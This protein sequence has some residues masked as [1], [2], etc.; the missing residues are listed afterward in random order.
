M[1]DKQ[2]FILPVD[3]HDEV[4]DSIRITD[5]RTTFMHGGILSGVTAEIIPEPATLLLGALAAVGMLVRRRKF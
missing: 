3:F 4:L 2:V 1:L 5:N